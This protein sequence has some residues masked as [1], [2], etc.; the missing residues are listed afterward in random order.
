[1]RRFTTDRYIKQEVRNLLKDVGS[2]SKNR[3][4]TLSSRKMGD[5]QHDRSCDG[6]E[7]MRHD[8]LVDTEK[9]EMR[10]LPLVDKLTEHHEP[11]RQFVIFAIYGLG[12][13]GKT[14]IARKIFD[15]RGRKV[16]SA[17]AYGCPFLKDPVLLRSY[18]QHVLHQL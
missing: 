10:I 5:D 3:P 15:D 1:M 12:G 8:N 18:R 14:T 2:V 16:L 11:S 17:H 7:L 4:P 13:V 6:Q 9:I